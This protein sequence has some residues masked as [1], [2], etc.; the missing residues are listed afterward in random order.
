MSDEKVWVGKQTVICRCSHIYDAT[1][2]VREPASP[3]EQSRPADLSQ[4]AL[5]RF[6]Q[7]LPSSVTCPKCGAVVAVP[8]ENWRLRPLAPGEYTYR[9]YLKQVVGFVVVLIILFAI[10]YACSIVQG[11]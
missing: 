5:T 3:S 9:P 1:C 4:G 7:P 10:A 2:E 11:R 8:P 6:G